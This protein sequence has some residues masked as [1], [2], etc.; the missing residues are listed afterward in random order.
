[1]DDVLVLRRI[2]VVYHLEVADEKRAVVERVHAMHHEH[3]PV[4]RSI[5]AAIDMTTELDLSPV[6][7]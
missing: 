3:C 1:M 7:G 6:E 4:Y 2:H 5:E